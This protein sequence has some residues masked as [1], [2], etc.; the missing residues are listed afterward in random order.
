MEKRLLEIICCPETRQPLRE[1][2]PSE[3]AR[4]LSFKAGN[5]EA[6]L[7]RQDEQVFYPIR[8]GIPLLISDEAIRLA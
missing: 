6:G 1:A 4:A 7:I 8:N 2:T 5:F 3:L